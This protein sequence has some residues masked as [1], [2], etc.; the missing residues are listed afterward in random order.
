M[1]QTSLGFSAVLIVLYEIN[2]NL[3]T[4]TEHVQVC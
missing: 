4:Q 1:P 3:I 2:I